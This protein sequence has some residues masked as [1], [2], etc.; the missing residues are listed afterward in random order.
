M[1]GVYEFF[2][3]KEYEDFFSGWCGLVLWLMFGLGVRCFVMVEECV[4]QVV[5]VVFQLVCYG[6]FF[7]QDLVIYCCNVGCVSVFGSDYQCLVCGDFG[8]FEVE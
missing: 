6:N 7:L 2:V 3:M 5:L 4:D 8:V 1:Y